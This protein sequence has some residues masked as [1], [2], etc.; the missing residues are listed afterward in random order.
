MGLFDRFKRSSSTSSGGAGRGVVDLRSD[1][2]RRM[3]QEAASSLDGEDEKLAYK[4]VELIPRFAELYSADRPAAD[5]VQEEI[6]AIGEH[7]CSNGGSAR[8]K[9]VGYRVGK[10]GAGKRVRIRDLE[11][12]WDGICGW[13]Y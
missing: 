13:M 6:K 3:E 2:E 8:M 7:L 1:R 5:K 4:L 11:F 12:H 10:L 9:R